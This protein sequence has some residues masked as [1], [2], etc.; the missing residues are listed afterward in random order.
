M[1]P[2]SPLVLAMHPCKLADWV[3]PTTFLLGLACAVAGGV[4][5]VRQPWF[6]EWWTAQ[7]EL[8]GAERA[9]VNLVLVRTAKVPGKFFAGQRV[10]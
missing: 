4:H 7:D 2:S 6:I 9:E 10:N 3:V 5:L 8:K 1:H